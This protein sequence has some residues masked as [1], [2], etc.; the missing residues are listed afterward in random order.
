MWLRSRKRSARRRGRDTT[1]SSSG[2]IIPTTRRVIAKNTS[3]KRLPRQVRGRGRR[4]GRRPLR[5]PRRSGRRLPVRVWVPLITLVMV[6]LAVVALALTLHDSIL[7]RPMRTTLPAPVGLRL[8]THGEWAPLHTLAPP[9]ALLGITHRPIL[10]LLGQHLPWPGQARIRR[11]RGARNA[12]R[13]VAPVGT[14]LMVMA[15]MPVTQGP[16]VT[17]ATLVPVLM[18]ARAVMLVPVVMAAPAVTAAHA[19]TAAQ[20]VTVARA[21]TAAQVTADQAVSVARA[22]SVPAA[23]PAVAVTAVLEGRVLLLQVQWAWA[24]AR[25][26]AATWAATA[27]R[28]TFQTW[29][30]RGT[31]AASSLQSTRSATGTDDLGNLTSNRRGPE[32]NVARDTCGIELCWRGVKYALLVRSSS[33]SCQ[34]YDVHPMLCVWCSLWLRVDVFGVTAAKVTHHTQE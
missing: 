12:V 6:S 4:R 30:W 25:T 31:T 26:V 24:L 18:A 15:A 1:R 34:A 23:V 22:A 7:R 19:V 3:A 16:A 29:S 2:T 32:M 13:P 9:P 20:A 17:E 27:S 28:T 21:V 10:A 11:L 33:S 8:K 5:G 14:A